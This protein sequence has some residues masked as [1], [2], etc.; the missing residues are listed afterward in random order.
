MQYE[1]L[2]TSKSSATLGS[3]DGEFRK[4]VPSGRYILESSN[5]CP[6]IRTIAPPNNLV[7]HVLQGGETRWIYLALIRSR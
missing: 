7:L 3:S 2:C 4:E 6:N 5:R 1:N